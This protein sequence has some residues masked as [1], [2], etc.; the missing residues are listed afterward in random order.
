MGLLGY[1]VWG[2]GFYTIPVFY[3]PLETEFG[4]A[5]TQLTSIGAITILA[6]S[7]SGPIVGALL[8]RIGVRAVVTAGVM[9]FGCSLALFGGSSQHTPATLSLI[10]CLNG[11]ACACVSLLPTQVLI[12]Q[13]FEHRR[14]TATGLALLLMALG[15]VINVVVAGHLIQRVGWRQTALLFDALTWGAALPLALFAL[16]EN[17]HARSNAGSTIPVAFDDPALRDALRSSQFYVLCAAVALNMAVGNALLQNLVLHVAGLGHGLTFG[18]YVMSGFVLA[19]LAARLLIAVLSDWTS[20]KTGALLSYSCFTISVCL[21]LTT[22][23]RIGLAA[24][25]FAAGFGYGGSILILG[26]LG[27]EMFGIRSLG[28][29]LG[30]VLLAMGVGS[31]C[32]TYVTSH[33]FD[34]T[35]KYQP[36]FALLLFL[37]VAAV[38]LIA[39]VRVEPLLNQSK[40]LARA[41]APA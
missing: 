38:A 34:V 26:V 30:L 20:L 40:R 5:R 36:A 17:K 21:L 23:S 14:T 6:Y 9:L 33:I 25:G 35:G 7:L 12:A 3:V 1:I 28:S 24:A 31:A 13:W 11:L 22:S 4:F 10:G 32:G 16:R 8:D 19:N 37:S 15:G 18:A 27:S 41:D 39:R 29:I 2:I